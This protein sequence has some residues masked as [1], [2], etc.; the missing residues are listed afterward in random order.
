M[1]IQPHYD[2][3]LTSSF[4]LLIDNKILSQGQAFTNYSSLFY[5]I[6]SY[7][8]NEYAYACPFK[9]LVNDISI[10]GANV[11][12][13]LY[14]NGN[15]VNIGQSGLVSINHYNGAAFFNTKLPTNT[16]I[17]GNYSVKDFN[18]KISDQPEYK[19][20]FETDYTTNGKYYQ[21]P[22]GIDLDA[23]TSPIIFLRTKMDNPVPFSLGGIENKKKTIRAIIIADSEYQRMAVCG[24]LKDMMYSPFYIK[25]GLPFDAMG[26]Y[27]GIPY[28]FNSLGN[29]N[30]YLPWIM[31]TQVVDVPRQGDFK[32]MPKNMSFVDFQV[33]TLAL[34]TY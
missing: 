2:N 13:G 20:L 11:I 1:G 24:I 18:I 26:N 29:D 28:N 6:N 14:L 19:L 16:I 15:Y 27:T 33:Q 34:H 10:S 25:T 8:S 5:P 9:S 30:T 17:S 23:E 22:T 21:S 7:I 12:S 3:K 32:T 31:K 4:M